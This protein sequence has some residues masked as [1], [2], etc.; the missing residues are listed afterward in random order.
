MRGLL[1]GVFALAG[2][3]GQTTPGL[4]QTLEEE[5]SLLLGDHPL[6][7]AGEKDVEGAD[8]GIDAAF[9][10]YLPDLSA[11]ADTGYEHTNSPARRNSGLG[12]FDAHRRQG[13][14]TLTE[15]LFDGFEREAN[16]EIAEINR[17]IA[18]TGL[19]GT[20]QDLLLAGARVYHDLLRQSRL[21]EL[22]RQNEER[23]KT[24]LRLED[25][26]VKRG[27]GIEVDVLF[28][29]TRLQIAKERRV[30][31]E[32]DLRDAVARYVQVFGRLPDRGSMVEPIAPVEL[33]PAD[34]EAALTLATDE[35]PDVREGQ[36]RVDAAGEERTVASSDYYPTLEL[37]ARGNVEEDVDGTDGFRDDFAVLV[38]LTWEIFSGFETRA[39]VAEASANYSASMSRLAFINREVAER[40]RIAYNAL[41]TARERVELL[42]NAVNIAAEV[43]AARQRLREAGRESAIDVLDAETELIEA[44]ID[45][46]NASYDARIAVYRVLA[47]TGLLT[48]QALGLTAKT[49]E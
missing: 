22:G 7:L 48:P 19:D 4:G 8:A 16:L 35:N 40:T 47:A 20:V 11:Q 30:G 49:A 18:E 15:K 24:Q 1:I 31:F 45:F 29:K 43:F 12:R 5:L 2:L 6:I 17:S 32:G 39:R 10:D 13:S 46:T 14:L 9:A 37:V 38:Q 34:L 3:L 26:R 28:A 25:E 36:Q 33:V 44:Q 23:I 21:V 27:S 42:Q 41:E